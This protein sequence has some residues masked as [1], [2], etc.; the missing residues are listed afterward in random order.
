MA[1][2]AFEDGI[3]HDDAVIAHDGEAGALFGV[4]RCMAYLQC[5]VTHLDQ[6]TAAEPAVHVGDRAPGVSHHRNLQRLSHCLQ[7]ADVIHVG[8]RQEDGDGFGVSE[9][10]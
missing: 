3:A 4:A 8:V 9:H 2:A 1:G 5:V 7:R 10:L 6:V